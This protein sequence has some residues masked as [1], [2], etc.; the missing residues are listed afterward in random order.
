[1]NEIN[2]NGITGNILENDIILSQIASGQLNIAEQDLTRLANE[3]T[4]QIKAQ[5]TTNI[6]T[7]MAKS[8]INLEKMNKAGENFATKQLFTPSG[9]AIVPQPHFT[10]NII[11]VII[12][13]DKE[14]ND[15][16]SL[17]I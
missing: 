11:P 16:N 2:E 3:I 13:D 7:F 4:N 10:S 15:D 1:M 6:E 8:S 14:S 5:S 12:N 17:K 9:D